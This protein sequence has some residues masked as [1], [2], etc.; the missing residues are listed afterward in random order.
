[1]GLSGVELV[2]GSLVIVLLVAVLVQNQSLGTLRER[3]AR[4]ERAV[5][6]EPPPG[7]S[8][9][10]PEVEQEVRGLVDSG[11]KILAIKVVRERTGLGLKEAKDLVDRF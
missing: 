7:S 3:V 5:R 8:G 10:T 1:V 2:L 9:L 4:V 6:P 11:Q